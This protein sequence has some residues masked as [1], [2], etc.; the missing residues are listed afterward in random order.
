MSVV[1][2]PDSPV[3]LYHQLAEALRY[4]IATGRLRPGQVLPPVR[5]GRSLYG[6]NLHTV[7]RAYAELARDGLVIIEGARGTRVAPRAEPWTSEVQTFVDRTIQSA[8]TKFGL[9]PSELAHLLVG[10]SP[11]RRI[12]TDPVYVLECSETQCTDLARELAQAW[13]IDARPWCL[14]CEGEP[15]P[16]VLVATYFHYNEI[17]LRWPHRLGQLR[18]ITIRPDA[19]LIRELRSRC[20][21]EGATHAKLCER[22]HSMAVNIIAD[23]D[24]MFA[25]EQLEV[26]AEVTPSPTSFFASYEGSDPVLFS[27]RVWGELTPAQRQ[28]PRAV[29]ARYVFDAQE[30]D[31]LAEE[32]DWPRRTPERPRP[33]T[34]RNTKK[35]GDPIRTTA[36]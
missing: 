29:Q 1:L 35:L 4:R 16:G 8:K 10:G 11:E 20:P 17:R 22:E 31:R 9:A 27:P 28:D 18:F 23:L 13:N 33:R 5:Q 3:P 30:L 7:R 26:V 12:E 15:P 2:D 19:A 6:V 25:A 21:R 36:G 34:P 24:A 32:L 14:S